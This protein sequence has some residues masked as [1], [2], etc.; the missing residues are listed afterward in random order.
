MD[1]VV[2]KKLSPKEK[3]RL[4]L[5]QEELEGQELTVLLERLQKQYDLS[6]NQMADAA[7]MDESALHKI[8]KGENREFKAEHV[9]ALLNELEQ[10]GRFPSEHERAIWQR[11]LRI[12]AFLH[13]A[14]YKAI[15]PR[16]RQI[17]DVGKRIESLKVYLRE[18][19]PS[20]AETYD[21]SGGTFPMFVPLFDV[22]AK[23]LHKR[24]GWI[25]VPLG[26]RLS[27][28]EG[29]RY[30]LVS[31]DLFP[32]EI[33]N[34]GQDLE[35][36]D[37][38]FGTFTVRGNVL[39]D[40]AKPTSARFDLRYKQ[41]GG[42]DFVRVPAGEFLM[43]SRNDN[44]LAHDNEKPQHT[45][46]I[47]CD[48]WMGQFPVT[49]EQYAKFVLAT[50]RKQTW[51]KD[52]VLKTD[53]PVVYVSW[54]DAQAYCKWLNETQGNE[55]PKGF[56]FR[57]PTEAEWEKAAR[58]E[59]GFEWPW[60]NEFDE[61]KCNFNGDGKGNT[62]PV[63]AYSPA[64]DSPYGAADM[65]GNVWEWTQSLFKGY[66]YQAGDGREDLKAQGARVLRGGSFIDESW[67]ARCSSRDRKSVDAF[68]NWIGNWSSG[69]RVVVSS[70]LS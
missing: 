8:L 62:T 13:F 2:H 40:A 54:D 34:L 5:L 24:Y 1:K 23:E 44:K 15:E 65:V 39:P 17:E 12:A 27:R 48:Y 69:F 70:P 36:E 31:T 53:H 3:K 33:H 6:V 22:L 60:G 37:T 42:I 25:R 51:V 52:W 10:Q 57:L 59:F 7:G 61:Y 50:N 18:Q 55:L 19:Y 35:I 4:Q 41:M 56:V 63:G 66:P 20:L 11:A 21:K 64:G 58:G 16:L 26:Y 38:G 67:Y 9:D 32:K 45:V 46:K 30:Y 47:S 29:N 68:G 43:G 49:N 14:I 28:V